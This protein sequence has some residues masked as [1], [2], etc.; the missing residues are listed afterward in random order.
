MG[1][2]IK[3]FTAVFLAL[4]PMDGTIPSFLPQKAAKS[5]LAGETTKLDYDLN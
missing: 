3:R 5:G 4:G 2:A 1:W